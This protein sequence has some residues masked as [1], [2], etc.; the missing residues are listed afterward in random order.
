MVV[1][2]VA[3]ILDRDLQA[4]RRQVEAYPDDDAIWRLPEGAPNSAG[5]LVLHLAG[6]LQHFFGARLGDTGY[7][8]DRSAEFSARGVTR[9][10]LLGQIEAARAAVRAAAKRI[11]DDALRQ[12]FP[13][14]VGGVRVTLGEYLIHLV[15]HFTYHLGQVDYHRRLVTRDQRGVEALRP[16]ELSSARPV[17]D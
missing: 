6:N 3:A 13:E 4:L 17:P 10:A 8:R 15:S 5:T 16:T 2:A 7:V 9:A 12:D 14:V 1:E 11:D